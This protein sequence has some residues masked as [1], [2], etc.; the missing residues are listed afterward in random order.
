LLTTL[1]EYLG[2][3][4]NEARF[5]WLY[6][7]GPFGE[8]RAWLLREGDGGALV[9]MAAVFP[10]LLASNG[11]IVN[12]CVLGDF[13]LAP[14][15]RTLGPG[16]QLQKECLRYLKNGTFVL[17]YD[18][19][20]AGMMVIYQRL[21][22]RSEEELVRFAKPLKV[23]REV[24][25]RVS[26]ERLAVALSG[27]GNQLLV[28][29]DRF[30]RRK[31]DWEISIHEGAIGEEFTELAER[32]SKDGGTRIM[33]ISSYVEWR[34]R[35]HPWR[36]HVILTARQK[37]RLAGYLI[38]AQDGGHALTADV[39]GESNPEML[40]ALIQSAVDLSRG[41]GIEA[42]SVSLL[43]TD[44]RSAVFQRMGFREREAR[45]VLLL[46]RHGEMKS[47]GW[48]LTDGDRES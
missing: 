38:L 9:G 14:S 10:R 16:V 20:S 13:C 34:F 22:Y 40:R 48:F 1:K 45:P 43:R 35:K 11:E 23:D 5:E 26:A 19:P 46:S 18:F 32:I 36:R 17:G 15:W 8:A 24:R 33:R 30:S 29:R 27:I 39:Y 7:R 25:E 31:T 12:G 3:P 6:C 2:P 37:G 47:S 42:I 44:P 21:G 28:W 4:E 41:C